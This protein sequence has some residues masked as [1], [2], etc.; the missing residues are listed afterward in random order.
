MKNDEQE[1]ASSICDRCGTEISIEE[2]RSAPASSEWDGATLCDDC[3]EE[4]T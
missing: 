1:S 2:A 4:A 3:Y